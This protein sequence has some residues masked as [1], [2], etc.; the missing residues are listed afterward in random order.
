MRARLDLSCR[1]RRAEAADA[2]AERA[3]RRLP[4]PDAALCPYHLPSFP[5]SAPRGFPVRKCTDEVCGPA[6][7]RYAR[8]EAE[9]GW[10]RSPQMRTACRAAERWLLASPH[11]LGACRQPP[12]ALVSPVPC[13]ASFCF[14]SHCHEQ[15]S[16]PT[17]WS[18][19]AAACRWCGW[20]ER[21]S[22][23]ACQVGRRAA[24]SFWRGQV[25]R[26]QVE[27][28]RGAE[29]A[30]LCATSSTGAL[31]GDAAMAAGPP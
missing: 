6:H 14:P 21:T 13:N 29:D 5:G 3:S 15:S 19:L 8:G 26:E 4:T 23:L 12:R 16:I 25:G 7:R 9:T 11:R 1:W 2:A 17:S 31:G 24:G 18:T 20:T 22:S 27:M 28:R 30:R 10:A